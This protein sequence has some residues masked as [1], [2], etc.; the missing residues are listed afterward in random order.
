MTPIP[1]WASPPADATA[2]ETLAVAVRGSL[3]SAFQGQTPPAATTDT[4]ATDAAG[5]GDTAA[6]DMVID[7]SPDTSRLVVIGS[8]EFLDD[9]ILNLSASMSGDRYLNNLQL[10]K[11][12]VDWCSEDLDLLGIR[13][14]GSNTHLLASLSEGQQS[15]WEGGQ[16]C[17]G[18]A[19]TGRPGRVLEPAASQR[20]ADRTADR[21]PRKRHDPFRLAPRGRCIRSSVRIRRSITEMKINMPP[22]LRI[23]AGLLVVQVGLAAFTFWPR[24]AAGQAA[25]ALSRSRYCRRL[26]GGCC[27]Q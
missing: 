18:L 4:A 7:T 2:A 20:K 12:A 14:R 21:D 3:T 5:S 8:G 19:G 17:A 23:L 10:L 22:L 25:A 6:N 24:A 16:L 13:A 9:T 15:F 11:N 26:Q 27:R 1:T